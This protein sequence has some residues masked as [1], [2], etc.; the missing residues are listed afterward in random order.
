MLPAHLLTLQNIQVSKKQKKMLSA[1]LLFLVFSS[2]YDCQTANAK[3]LN[4]STLSNSV[5]NELLVTGKRD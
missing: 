3:T 5:T 2:T 4:E 1:L